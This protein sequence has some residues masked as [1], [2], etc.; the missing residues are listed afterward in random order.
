VEYFHAR[1]E[2]KCAKHHHLAY[3]EVEY[4]GGFIDQHYAQ[5]TQRVHTSN[6]YAVGNV[7]QYCLHDITPN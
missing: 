3:G 7:L 6:H 5:G 4:A 2:E 1:P